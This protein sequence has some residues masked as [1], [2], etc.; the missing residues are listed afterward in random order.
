M[1]SHIEKEELWGISHFRLCDGVDGWAKKLYY[2]NGFVNKRLEYF[3]FD[4]H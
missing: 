4:M 2:V 3:S 1:V